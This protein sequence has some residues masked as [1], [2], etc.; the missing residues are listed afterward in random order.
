MKAYPLLVLL[1]CTA[2]ATAEPVLSP[3]T[4]DI[5]KELIEINTT[6][7]GD[8]AKAARAMA[9][10]LTAAGFAKADVRVFEPAPKRGN[11]VARLR[12]TGKNKPMILLAHLDVVE[13]KREDWSTDPFQLVDKDGFY[14]ARGTSDDKYMAAA[15]VANLIRYKKENYKPDRDLILVLEADEEI[16]D[17]HGYGITWLLK[18]HKELLE[19]EFALNEGGGVA[20]KDGKPAWNNL[21]AS[22]KLFQTFTVEARNS[23]GHSSQ[24]RKD[25]AIYELAAGLLNVEKLK[26]P[27]HLNDTTKKY[28]AAM[29]AIETGQTAADMKALASAKPDASAVDRLSAVPRYNAQLRTT[30]VATRLE[31]GHADN[32]LPQLARATVNCRICPGE[33]VDEVQKALETALAN[34][35]L[36]VAAAQ[37]DV[38]SDPSPIDRELVTA[39]EGLT[40]KFWPGIP[41][42]PVMSAGFTDGRILRNA[43]IPTYGHSGLASDVADSRAHGKDE[44]VSKQ[45]FAE[46][47]EYLYQLVQLLAGGT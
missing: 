40:A 13:A 24:P 26:F 45:A 16:A 34:P 30:C 28:F 5:F 36:V 4:R 33:S 43:G 15:W 19:A 41:V 38:G 23:G 9:K 47:Q 11:L 17:I 2:V 20:V 6:Q 37:R 7:N 39:I 1:S 8:T 25:N 18:N 31:G 10:R 27:V 42:I 3:L 22:E 46:G 21:Q 32:A 14:Y 35:K 44:R 29:A 12:G